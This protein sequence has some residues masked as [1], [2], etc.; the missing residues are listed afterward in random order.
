MQ[1]VP[2]CRK[3]TKQQIEKFLAAHADF[4]PIPYH[5]ALGFEVPSAHP[6]YLSLTPAHH[7][8]DGFFAAVMERAAGE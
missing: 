3:K 2:C 7:G 6:D 1:P 8:T 5:T 4:K